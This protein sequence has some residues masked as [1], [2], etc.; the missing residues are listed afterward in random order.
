MPAM[1]QTTAFNSFTAALCLG[2][3]SEKMVGAELLSLNLCL[4]EIL[5][6]ERQMSCVTRVCFVYCILVPFICE[7]E[8][9]GSFI[10]TSP[11]G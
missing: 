7:D 9:L 4:V 5:R 3:S 10:L 6:A 11:H 2:Q 8:E 1:L